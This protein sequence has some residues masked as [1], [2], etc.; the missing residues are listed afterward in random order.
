MIK[1]KVINQHDY[2]RIDFGNRRGVSF[3]H[4]AIRATG[5]T[6]QRVFDLWH[7]SMSFK[8]EAL[9]K[10]GFKTN[11]K[12]NLGE[13][14][15]KFADNISNVWK[16]WNVGPKIPNVGDKIKVDFGKGKGT[17]TG[18]VT[19]VNGTT[20]IANFKGEGTFRVPGDRIE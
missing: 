7:N 19:K 2:I 6:P 11:D 1:P 10:I 18:T 3:S 15:Q 12:P 8:P 5:S 20:V 16:D 9:K 4:S 17:K 13:I 14:A